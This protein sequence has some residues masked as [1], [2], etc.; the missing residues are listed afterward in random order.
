M[1]RFIAIL[2]MVS[3]S[4]CQKDKNFDP[5]FNNF[6]LIATWISSTGTPIFEIKNLKNEGSIEKYYEFIQGQDRYL[7]RTYNDYPT[8]YEIVYLDNQELRVV[9]R[10]TTN[11]FTFYKVKGW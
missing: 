10:N 5:V 4:S 11:E 1:K 9:E 8:T 6:P 3:L 7:R 2:L